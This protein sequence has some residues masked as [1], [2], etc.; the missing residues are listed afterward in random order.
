MRGNDL[1][2]VIASNVDDTSA[3]D[4][5]TYLDGQCV[6]TQT[7]KAAT[8]LVA[9]DYV[10]FK[11]SATLAAT[12]GTKLTGGADDAAVTGE[13]HQAFLDKL[14]AYAFNTLCCPATELSLIHI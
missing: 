6:D 9:N 5:S 13:D 2:I 10:V 3:W 1:S 8:D 4:V 12:A 11:T 14:E 7:V